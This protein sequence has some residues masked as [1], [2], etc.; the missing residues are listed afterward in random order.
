LASGSGQSIPATT[1]GGNVNLHSGDVFL[2]HITYDGTTLTMT[3]TDATMQADTFATFVRGE[4]NGYGGWQHCACGLT[5]GTGGS[6]GII[7]WSFTI[8]S[9][10]H[11]RVPRAPQKQ[12][13]TTGHF[14]TWNSNRGGTYRQVDV[15][16]PGSL[17]SEASSLP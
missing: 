6:T 2:V 15:E 1:L 10:I 4:H 16:F 3:I 11:A 12:S 8:L 7:T 14:V 5:A 17:A 13:R 9:G